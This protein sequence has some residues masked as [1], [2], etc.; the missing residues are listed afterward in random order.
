MAESIASSLPAGAGRSQDWYWP[1]PQASQGVNIGSGVRSRNSAVA[2]SAQT[3][4]I[5]GGNLVIAAVIK[6]VPCAQM[7]S[8][9]GGSGTIFKFQ[10]PMPLMLRTSKS[11]I[12]GAVDDQQVYRI[13][14]TMAGGGIAVNA[15]QDFGFEVIRT[16]GTFGR[17]F[18]DA[19]DGFGIRI[20]DSHIVQFFVRGPNGL[21]VRNLTA[22]PFDT[23]D[24][25]SFDF[26]ISSATDAVDAKLALL[27]D[28]VAVDLGAANSSWAAGT[29]LPA[30]S[31][32]N[33]LMGFTPVLVSAAGNDNGL[34]V[35]Q[36]HM[37]AAPSVLMTL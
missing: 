21:I 11:K 22:A 15:G 27:M 12:V 33:G 14:V 2:V 5:G 34:F 3:G 32:L 36:V 16:I 17:V 28:T 7:L 4:G 31:L 30:T 23:T 13:V 20:Q 26:R 29:N 10:P 6:G 24:W 35:Q 25:H 37:M 9:A 18:A 19:N 1:D 8:G